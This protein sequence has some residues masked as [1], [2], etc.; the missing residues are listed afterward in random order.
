MMLDNLLRVLA[1]GAFHSGSELG[2]TLG[3]SRSAV[4]KHMQRLQELGVEVYSVKGRGYRIPGGLD[5]LDEA[6]LQQQLPQPVRDRLGQLVLTVE[7]DSTN[8]RALDAMQA[9]LTTGLFASEYQHSGRGRRGRQWVSPLGSSLCFSLA[10]RFNSGAAALEGLSLAVGL[11]LQQALAQEGLVNIGLKWPNDLLVNDAKL[12]GI[13]IEL[14]GDAA[15]ECQVA[16]GIGLNVQLPEAMVEQ[17]D[18]PC[19]DLTQLGY[20]G[21]K[22]QLLATVVSELIHMLERF[23]TSGFAPLRS[24]WEEANAFRG[25]E[26][27]LTSGPRRYEGV[28]LGVTDQGGLRLQTSAGQEVFH[29]GEMS[30]RLQ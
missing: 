28:C 11:A 9:G 10:W 17:L 23:E 21:S 1:D 27:A 29:G 30:V 16:I 15:G 2:R 26:V 5:L 6:D 3:I 22:T 24:A 19:V 4:W 13:L 7:T 8:T 14:S 12:G 20:S 25:R 18:Q